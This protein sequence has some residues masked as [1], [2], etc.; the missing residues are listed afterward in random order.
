ML[1][2]IW[3]GGQGI[4]HVSLRIEWLSKIDSVAYPASS[5]RKTALDTIKI[6]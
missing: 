3:F 6:R 5:L 1:L 4:V 2:P